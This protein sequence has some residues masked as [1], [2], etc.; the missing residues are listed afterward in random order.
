MIE[1]LEV[2]FKLFFT[3]FCATSPFL[4]IGLIFFFLKK[5]RNKKYD[6]PTPTSPT[7]TNTTPVNYQNANHTHQTGLQNPFESSIN[8]DDIDEFY[9]NTICPYRQKYLL[10]K[11][12]WYFY[13]DLKQIADEL[14]LVVLAK[15]RMADLVEV[16]LSDKNQWRVY[17][18]KISKKH[19]DFAL[20][21]PDNLKIVLLIE[22]DDNTHNEKQ[23]E[24]DRFIESVYKKTGYKLL[25]VHNSKNLKEKIETLL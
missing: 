5:R 21:L 25:R 7:T 23:Y 22:L 2:G 4:L 13:K 14:N 12:E 19:I 18:N 20:A 9:D 3:L 24:R 8:K 10:T 6:I 1:L 15:I 17:F 11:N 16:N